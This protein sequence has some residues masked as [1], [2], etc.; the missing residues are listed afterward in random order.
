MKIK[1]EKVK[2]VNDEDVSWILWILPH[3]CPQTDPLS[4]G[5]SPE[6]NR[7]NKWLK[8]NA[9]CRG[10]VEGRYRAELASRH[11]LSKCIINS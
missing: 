4:S 8:N 3:H 7:L 9:I 6:E 2:L 5:Q 11:C 10:G 1:K